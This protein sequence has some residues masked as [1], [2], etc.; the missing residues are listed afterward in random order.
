MKP[1]LGWRLLARPGVVKQCLEAAKPGANEARGSLLAGWMSDHCIASAAVPIPL[2]LST[3]ELWLQGNKVDL[4]RRRP[5]VLTRHLSLRPYANAVIFGKLI[6]HLAWNHVL[7]RIS[8]N[9]GKV[10]IGQ[11]RTDESCSPKCLSCF[12]STIAWLI[13]RFLCKGVH[14]CLHIIT[15]MVRVLHPHGNRNAFAS[16]GFGLWASACW[17]KS[18]HYKLSSLVFTWTHLDSVTTPTEKLGPGTIMAS[19]RLNSRSQLLDW[20]S[21]IATRKLISRRA[22]WGALESSGSR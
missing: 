17:L 22:C 5:D 19:F 10:A 18:R 14:S 7:N 4:S 11:S 6:A 3:E 16:K 8:R 21:S 1:T 15:S 12:A 20:S 9:F 13:H 2:L